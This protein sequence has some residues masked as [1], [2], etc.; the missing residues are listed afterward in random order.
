MTFQYWHENCIYNQNI[1]EFDPESISRVSNIELLNLH[2]SN[3]IN[4][5]YGLFRLLIQYL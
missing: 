4:K 2:I 1:S 3:F 5:N